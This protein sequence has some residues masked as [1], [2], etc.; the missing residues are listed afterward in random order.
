MLRKLS[1][2]RGAGGARRVK[3]SGQFQAFALIDNERG[4]VVGGLA[5]FAHQH[6]LRQ[7]DQNEDDTS[8]AQD[9]GAATAQNV[10]APAQRSQGG[11][12]REQRP[13]DERIKR[14]PIG[15]DHWSLF[16]PRRCSRIGTCTWSVL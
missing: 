10:E 5:A 1:R 8:S 9:R 2:Q 3:P 13:R 12:R 16:L 11:K 6:R 15:A 4:D 14:E 7:A